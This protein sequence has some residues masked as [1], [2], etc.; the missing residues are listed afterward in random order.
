M[1]TI[2]NAILFSTALVVALVAPARSPGQEESDAASVAALIGT[3]EILETNSAT[4]KPLVLGR[5]LRQDDRVR[6]DSR[7]AVKLLYRDDCVVDL[8][9]DSEMS[10]KQFTFDL[11]EK[12]ILS[13]LYLTRGT[14]GVLVSPYYGVAPARFEVETPS[15]VSS[16]SGTEFLIVHDAQEEYS[17]I[18]N[19]GRG[20]ALVHG[21]IGVL[22]SS[23]KVG[24]REVLRVYRG[25]VPASPRK[26]DVSAVRK[27]RED[28][29][30]SL[31][32]AQSNLSR[33]HPAYTSGVVDRGDSPLSEGGRRVASSL[34]ETYLP[35]P[36]S[37][38]TLVE[39]LSPDMRANTQSLP[40]FRAAHPGE[41]PSGGVGVE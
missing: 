32:D 38:D 31:V 18:V 12:R 41:V 40:E 20:D 26:I 15:A 35:P 19:L 8:G 21:T 30:V 6:T 37:G 7:A 13:Q 17:D 10:V 28:L 16:L 24:S 39:S 25:K 4:W 36:P 2:R 3:P 27:Y 29:N 5:S 33:N 1:M 11:A 34:S 9:A 22:G 23:V 14:V